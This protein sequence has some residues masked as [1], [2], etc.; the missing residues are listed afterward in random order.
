MFID[1]DLTKKEREIQK[2]IRETA[3]KERKKGNKTRMGY[4]KL[5]VNG[6]WMKWQKNEDEFKNVYF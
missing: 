5:E 1:D 2:K 4:Q 3:D 6:V